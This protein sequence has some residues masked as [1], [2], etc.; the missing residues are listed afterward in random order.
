MSR[1]LSS[2]KRE[3]GLSLETLQ[4]KRASSSVQARISSFA[5]SCAR[6]LRVP[7]ELRVDLGDLLVSP[8]GSQIS[9]GVARCTSGFQ[10]NRCR[11]E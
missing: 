5:W 9:F 2:S 11:D 3:R 1:T 7:L 10:V 4:R 6:K 8:Q